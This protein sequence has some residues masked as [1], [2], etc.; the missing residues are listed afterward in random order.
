MDIGNLGTH[1]ALEE[2]NKQR[3]ADGKTTY[4]YESLLISVRF[5]RKWY[6]P[7]MHHLVLSVASTFKSRA[8][9]SL[10]FIKPF[11][12]FMRPLAWRSISP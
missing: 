5:C 8:I 2:M 11:S 3:T 9:P 10:T 12:V 7:S 1:S 4:H 6:S